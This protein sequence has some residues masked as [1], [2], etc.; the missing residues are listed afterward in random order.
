MKK[1]MTAMGLVAVMLIGVTHAFA[2]NPGAQNPGRGHWGMGH[3]DLGQRGGLS[4]TPEQR[5]K[6]QE[7]RRRFNDETAQLKG[8]ILTKRLE[9]QSLW[10]DPKAD[11]KAITE[12]EK[13]L[14]A[15]K[16]QLRD[17]M[18]QYKLEARKVLTPEQISQ[19][20]QR[21]EM[22]NRFGRGHMGGH[23]YGMGNRFDR[24]QTRGHGYAMG[25]RFD[26]RHM[27]GHGY[28]MGQGYEGCY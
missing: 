1:T 7:L 14:T 21:R 9:L 12:K 6:F 24:G 10:T 28:G 3:Q 19:L 18:V 26:R 5:T 17:K 23:G 8:A 15:L 22:G 4:L 27:R 25:N 11:P 20:A 2:Q 16:G 13:E